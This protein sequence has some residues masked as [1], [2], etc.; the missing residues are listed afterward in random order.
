MERGIRDGRSA[1][2]SLGHPQAPG[3]Y[4]GYLLPHGYGGK[5]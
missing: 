4:D 3:T 5:P 2:G 1:R